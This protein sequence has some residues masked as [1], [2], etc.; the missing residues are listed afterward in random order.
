MNETS[1]TIPSDDNP[2][3]KVAVHEAAHTVVAVLL[4][5]TQENVTIEPD[6]D[7]GSVIYCLPRRRG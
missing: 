2:L 5:D 1:M 6:I 3:R 7:E 4:E